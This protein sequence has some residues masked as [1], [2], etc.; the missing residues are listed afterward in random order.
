MKAKSLLTALAL[1]A[2]LATTALAGDEHGHSADSAAA[3]DWGP[4]GPPAE[5]SE[6]M[7]MVGN[8]EG[9][10]AMKMAPDAPWTKSKATTS[11]ETILG[12]GA[13]RQHFMGE[14]MGMPLEGW[15]TMTFDRQE[16]QYEA[17]WIDNMACREST[18]HGNFVDGTLVLTGI[19]IHNGQTMHMRYTTNK[20]SDDKYDWVMEQSMDGEN[21][22][23]GMKISYTRVSDAR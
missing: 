11:C 14:V 21:W 9:D 12:G 4:M 10:V 19:D 1:S 20:I 6:V 16:G 5:L 13:L 18:S 3:G 8:W 15:Y 23:D 17:T 7:Y 22:F 2:L